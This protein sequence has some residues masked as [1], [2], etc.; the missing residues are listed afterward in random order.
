M[1]LAK[2]LSSRHSDNKLNKFS[3]NMLDMG[4]QEL[5]SEFST[6]LRKHN[7]LIPEA[8]VPQLSRKPSLSTA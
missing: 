1:Y 8:S 3:H 5:T 4:M 2:Q 7:D 6:F